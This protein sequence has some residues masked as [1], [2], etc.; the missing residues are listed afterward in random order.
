[1]RHRQYCENNVLRMPPSNHR[2]FET[3]HFGG[4]LHLRKFVPMHRS[5]PCSASHRFVF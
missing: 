2:F 3:G 4:P 5:M 1:M